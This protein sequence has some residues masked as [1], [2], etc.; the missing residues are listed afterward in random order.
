M[1]ERLLTQLAALAPSEADRPELTT[2]LGAISRCYRQADADRTMLA[3][4]NDALIADTSSQEQQAASGQ[5]LQ[6]LIPL[7]DTTLDRTDDGLLLV[8]GNGQPLMGNRAFLTMFDFADRDDLIS[9]GT[10]WPRRLARRTL[11]GFR[12]GGPI[13][14]NSESTL[15]EMKDGRRIRCQVLAGDSADNDAGRIWCF[16]DMTSGGCRDCSA[17]TASQHD[18]L[19]GL[20][21]R[22]QF[23]GYL[24]RLLAGSDRFTLLMLGLDG[25]RAVNDSLGPDVG[26]SVLRQ[27]AGRLADNLPR[28]GFL[29]RHVADEFVIVVRDTADRAEAGLLA[30]NLRRALEAP[31]LADGHEVPLSCS[32]GLTVHPGNAEGA[33]SLIRQA[34]LAMR[35]AK[36]QGRNSHQFFS[37]ALATRTC[38]RGNIQSQLSQALSDNE[39]RMLYQPKIDLAT[40]LVTGVEALIRWHRPDGTVISPADFIPT[41][42]A[43]GLIIPISDWVLDCVCRQ[44]ERWAP[45]VPPEFSVAVNISAVHF[46]RGDVLRSL[47]RAMSRYGTPPGQ[48]ELEITE[49]M[50]V[51]DLATAT[52]LLGQIRE[53]GLKTAV[54]DF[55]T[56]YS[57]LNYLKSLPLDVLKIDKSFID[58]LAYSARGMKLVRTIIQLAHDLDMTVVAEG[59]ESESIAQF[60]AGHGCDTAQGYFFS[61]PLD[62]DRLAALLQRGFTP[63]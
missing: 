1:H 43:S 21:D 26:D 53:R 15:L 32:I 49:G 31:F 38:H 13:D 8:D 33:D 50:I 24:N 20:P 37:G 46:R 22:H 57:S 6:Q 34:A 9:E 36:D 42:E 35:H 61:R 41:A 10:N 56:G 44:L 52:R 7:L 45:I 55:G 12:A 63:L 14:R 27:A 48:L 58:D 2:L 59:I 3:R 16:T 47:E 18:R 29:A 30:D 17:G 51:E 4:M 11:N 19:T 54:D 28:Q 60:L 62:P 25:F 5:L 23:R 39:F 40:G